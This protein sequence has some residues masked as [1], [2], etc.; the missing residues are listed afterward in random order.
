MLLP[1]TKRLLEFAARNRLPH[2]FVDLDQD[3]EAEELLRQLGVAPED[4]PVVVL[5]EAEVL[6]NPDN[7]ELARRLGLRRPEPERVSTTCWWSVP[8]PPV[9]PLLCTAPRTG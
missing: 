3:R 8:A 5:R 7:A 4:T 9:S 6:R 1:D 2:R